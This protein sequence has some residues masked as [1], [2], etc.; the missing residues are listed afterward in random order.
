MIPT[1]AMH[2]CGFSYWINGEVG[3]YRYFIAQDNGPVASDTC[4]ETVV[5]AN[6]AARAQVDLLVKTFAP[7]TLT[8]I[9]QSGKG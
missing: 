6:F 1:P 3:A 4:F 8:S 5:A 9:I 7:T 2:Y